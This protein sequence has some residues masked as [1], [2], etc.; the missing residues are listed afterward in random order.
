MQLVEE[1]GQRMSDEQID[2]I[3]QC[4]VA[5]LPAPQA[6]EALEVAAAP[7]ADEAPTTYA[8]DEHA[9]DEDAFPEDHFEHEA[10]EAPAD[11]DD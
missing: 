9:M 8:A 11:E 1:L 6:A 10:P 4:V 3:L 7:V 5:H 2:D